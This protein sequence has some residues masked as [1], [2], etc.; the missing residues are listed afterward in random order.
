MRVYCELKNK[1]YNSVS[2]NNA[3]SQSIAI[4]KAKVLQILNSFIS[5]R[6]VVSKPHL[7]T[8]TIAS[9]DPVISL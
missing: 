9:S 3:H 7:E 2:F 6:Q 5:D 4:S 1:K 8:N